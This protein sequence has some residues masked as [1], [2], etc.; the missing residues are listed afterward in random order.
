M[1]GSIGW[2]LHLRLAAGHTPDGKEIKFL[3]ADA[4]PPA[5]LELIA[6][7]EPAVGTGIDKDYKEFFGMVSALWPSHGAK[8]ATPIELPRI[9]MLSGCTISHVAVLQLVYTFLGGYL[10]KDWRAS[11]GDGMWARP[12]ASLPVGLQCYLHGDVQQV[13]ITAWVAV[14]VWVSHI[15]PDSTLVTRATNLAPTDI[16]NWWTEAVIKGLMRRGNWSDPRPGYVTH[17]EG[18]IQRAGVPRTEPLHAVLRLCPSW[19]AITSGGCR[20]FHHAGLFLHQNYDLLRFA[21]IETGQNAWPNHDEA[22]RSHLFT[23][24]IDA[25]ALPPPSTLPSSLDARVIHRRYLHPFFDLLPEDVTRQNFFEAAEKI[26]LPKRQVFLLYHKDDLDRAVAALDLWESQPHRITDML[27]L[28]RGSL[29]VRDC[30]ELLWSTGR[31]RKRPADWVDPFHL[32]EQAAAKRQ[33]LVTHLQLQWATQAE[34]ARQQLAREAALQESVARVL[35]TDAIPAGAAIGP[36]LTTMG[37]QITDATVSFTGRSRSARRRKRRELTAMEAI[38]L[39]VPGPH[40]QPNRVKAK[41]SATGQRLGLTAQTEPVAV[42]QVAAKSHVTA[43]L[44]TAPSAQGGAE[45]GSRLG[46]TAQTEPAKAPPS[47]KLPISYLPETEDISDDE[48]PERPATP[49][50]SIPVIETRSVHFAHTIPFYQP[51]SPQPGPSR[52][53]LPTQTVTAARGRY[54][55]RSRSSDRQPGSKR[56]AT[57]S[58]QRQVVE[59]PEPILEEE[60]EEVLILGVTPDDT[61]FLGPILADKPRK[62]RR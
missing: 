15:F 24:G 35:A 28:G 22:G 3:C 62:R 52:L 37:T 56:A 58:P 51:S 49:P 30:R 18:A 16:L 8:P 31:L 12:Y 20:E 10:C 46:L 26:N 36:F 34:A 61:G 40:A 39:R 42:P 7:L 6:L 13:A 19:P 32:D 47:G 41:G 1:Y 25:L 43:P 57:P 27:G 50:R 60:D 23:L 45:V 55:S 33:R 59:R 14:T 5:Y 29:L 54:R 4:L 53:S 9:T 2:Q 44:F 11:T 48:M 38:G 21:G 17:R